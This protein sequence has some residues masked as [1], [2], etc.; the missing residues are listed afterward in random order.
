VSTGCEVV[1]LAKG[2]FPS[3][4]SGFHKKDTPPLRLEKIVVSILAKAYSLFTR[5]RYVIGASGFPDESSLELA[6]N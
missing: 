5:D 6:T 2:M 1:I 4:I 3:V